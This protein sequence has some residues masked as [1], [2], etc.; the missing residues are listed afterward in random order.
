MKHFLFLLSIAALTMTSSCKKN[1]DAHVPPDLS[2]STGAGYTSGD[3]TV[4]H[5]DSIL[6]GVTIVKK[7]DDLRTINLSYSYDGSA[8]SVSFLTYTMTPAEYTGYTHDY[9]IHTRNVAGTEKWTFTV[10]DR[11]GNLAQ[12]SITLTVQ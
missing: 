6:V 2:F 8:S 11:D 4:T 1:K 10:T 7:E 12:K 5:G 9:T 3:A